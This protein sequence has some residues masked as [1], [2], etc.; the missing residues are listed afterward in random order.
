MPG[1][2]AGLVLGQIEARAGRALAVP[3]ALL[4]LS[5]PRAVFCGLCGL[6]GDDRREHFGSF[7]RPT[8]AGRVDIAVAALEAYDGFDRLGRGGE[9]F[10]VWLVWL[11]RVASQ[12]ALIAYS[13]APREVLDPAREA[14]ERSQRLM[15][16]LP[17]PTG[18]RAPPF[19]CIAKRPASAAL[20]PPEGFVTVRLSSGTAFLIRRNEDALSLP[21][22]STAAVECVEDDDE[23]FLAED[24][25]RFGVALRLARIGSQP[26]LFSELADP[27]Y[28]RSLLAVQA[29]YRFE[30]D[31]LI[32]SAALAL[33]C[34]VSASSRV[35][36]EIA[37]RIL[38]SPLHPA[39][40]LLLAEIEVKSAATSA[41][42]RADL[43]AVIPLL[44]VA[45]E[46]G[47]EQE[48]ALQTAI[49]MWD[50]VAE[51][52]GAGVMKEKVDRF[53]ETVRSLVKEDHGPT[54]QMYL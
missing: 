39:I 7:G 43:E 49:E 22:L 13:G 12:E 53:R 32:A 31:E 29:A 45:A 41:K 1:E 6:L 27:Q 48:G 54:S 8:R 51:A 46:G 4:V 37:L 14:L 17:V 11:A 9:L 28:L 10:S 20:V 35:S 5:E 25:D 15:A 42:A 34:G 21:A 30:P 26:L 36:L 44:A 52:G 24:D 3:R 50:K 40:R 16:S 19:A 47:A 18:E 2:I 23:I 38:P 33:Q